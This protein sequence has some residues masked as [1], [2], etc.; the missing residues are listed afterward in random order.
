MPTRTSPL[1][2]IFRIIKDSY[3]GFRKDNVLKLSASLA[4]YTV[5]ALPALALVLISLTGIFYGEEAA[6][7]VL[8]HELDGLIGKNAAL[9][10]QE[11]IEKRR[12][13][14]MSTIGTIIGA[15]MLLLSASGI[16]GEIQDSINKIWGL[17]AKPKKGFLTMLFNRVMSF[18]LVLGL[19]FAMLVSLVINGLIAALKDKLELQFP[20]VNVQLILILD[21]IIQVVIITYL[22]AIIFKM[23]PDARIKWRDVLVGALTTTILFLAG[24]FFLGFYLTRNTSIEAY[25]AAGSIVLIMLW[26]Y[27][28]SAILYFGAEFTQ[29]YAKRFGSRI[30]PNKYATWVEVHTVEVSK[31]TINGDAYYREKGEKKQD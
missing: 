23:L 20:N 28:S 18:S 8:Y 5:F 19:G 30:M 9:Q 25:G 17:K 3:I 24:K 12:L 2:K 27:Y 11:A 14:G 4:Y 6:S 10:I 15:V 13:A 7:G 31:P 22:F 1:Y 21:Y 26:A 16:F 29:V